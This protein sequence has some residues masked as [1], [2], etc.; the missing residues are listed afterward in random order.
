MVHFSILLSII[1]QMEEKQQLFPSRLLGYLKEFLKG[2]GETM[3]PLAA[4]LTKRADCLY[5]ALFS[6]ILHLARKHNRVMPP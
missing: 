3:V 4:I 2:C 1:T 6:S 5:G